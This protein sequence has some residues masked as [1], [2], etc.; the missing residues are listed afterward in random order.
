MISIP[1][2]ALLNLRTLRPLYPAAFAVLNAPQWISLH[3]ALQFRRHSRPPFANDSAPSLPR[4]AA[5]ATAE[6]EKEKE[7]RRR[8][9]AIPQ[10]KFWPFLASLPRAFPTMPLTWSLHAKPAATL[11]ADFVIP[12][13][14]PSLVALKARESGDG[15]G[16]GDGESVDR[17]GRKR[18]Q[19]DRRRRYT[20][21][22]DCVPAAARRKAREVEKRFATDWH[23]VRKL[24]VR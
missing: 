6:Q 24:W 21:L 13:T 8:A 19:R 15:D 2:A 10:D 12:A 23:A 11:E 14:D 20:D 18:V 9:A 7:K 3:L 17:A 4:A 22:L 1:N 16:D 5:A